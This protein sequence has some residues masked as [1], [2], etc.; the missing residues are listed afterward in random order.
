[1]PAG[2]DALWRRCAGEHTVAAVRSARVLAWR[3]P[4]QPGRWWAAGRQGSR[5]D[6][7]AIL[8]HVDDVVHVRDLFGG[9]A[10]VA[11]LLPQLVFAAYRRGASS[12]SMR[13]L[14]DAW[15]SDLLLAN[16]FEARAADRMIF[17]GVAPKLERRLQTVL[18]DPACWLLTDFDEDV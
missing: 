9:R 13:Y 4:A 8:D 1:M 6:A 18:A 17:V 11:M 16:R 2:L 10:A 12:I 7:Y 5:L 3:Y 15:L 14:G